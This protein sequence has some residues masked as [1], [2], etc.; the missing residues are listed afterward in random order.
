MLLLSGWTLPAPSLVGDYQQAQS[1]SLRDSTRLQ[2]P[3]KPTCTPA[4]SPSFPPNPSGKGRKEEQTHCSSASGSKRPFLQ[5]CPQPLVAQVEPARQGAAAF[6]ST[7]E[8]ST[9]PA[10]SPTAVVNLQAIFFSLLAVATKTPLPA[11]GTVALLHNLARKRGYIT[12]S[13]PP[14]CLSPHSL[15]D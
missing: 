8:V 4:H 11:T 14:S 9:S 1:Q 10:R 13:S 3:K 7:K 12:Y 5:G 2:V 15:S 6:L